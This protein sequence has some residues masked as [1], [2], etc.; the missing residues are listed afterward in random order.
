MRIRDSKHQVAV[1]SAACLAIGVLVGCSPDASNDGPT[2]FKTLDGG[3]GGDV[4]NIDGGATDTPGQADS[5]SKDSGP[6]PVDAGGPVDVPLP[7][8]VAGPKTCTNDGQCTDVPVGPCESPVCAFG[9]CVGTAAPDGSICDDG[10]KCSTGHVCAAGQCQSGKAVNCDDD[11]ECTADSCLADTGCIHEA[12]TAPCGDGDP[13]SGQ[14]QCKGG[15]CEGGNTIS[16][17]D[18]NACTTDACNPETGTCSYQPNTKPCSDGNACTANDTCTLGKCKG[19]PMATCASD[20][21]CNK[22]FC[23]PETGKCEQKPAP[24]KCDDGDACTTGDTC[25]GGNCDAE[26]LDCDDGNT[27]TDDSCLG[28]TGCVHKANA[29]GC[30]DTGACK[31]GVCK[32]GKCQVGDKTGC[33]DNNPCTKDACVDKKGCVFTPL[34]DGTGCGDGDACKGKSACKAGKCNKGIATDCD[35]N[36]ACTDDKCDPKVGCSWVANTAA[37]NDGNACTKTDACKGGKCAGSGAVKCNDGNACTSDGCNA[38]TGCVHKSIEGQKCDDGSSC[39]TG[40][41]CKGGKCAAAESKCDDGKV[42]TIDNC[43][44]KGN[45]S[46]TGKTGACDDGNACTKND[47]CKAGKCIGQAGASCNDGNPCTTDSCDKVAGKCVHKPVVGDKPVP[48]DDG[49]VCTSGETCKAGKCAPATAA[50][51][52]DGNDCTADT[53]DP[54][55]GKCSF[56]PKDGPCDAGDVCTWGDTC[57]NGKCIAG[58]NQTCNDG[59]PCTK[60]SCDAKTGKCSYAPT[61]DGAKCDD[62]LA[63]STGDTCK[64][65]KCT[66]KTSNCMLYKVDFTCGKAHGWQFHNQSNNT[67]KWAVDKTPA[68]AALAKYGCTMNLNDGKDYCHATQ[69]NYC[70]VPSAWVESPLIDATKHT[71]KLRLHFHTYYDLDGP[72]GSGNPNYDRPRI[73]VRGSQNQLLQTILLSKEAKGCAGVPCQKKLLVLQRDIDVAS[74][75]K[76]RLRLR[77]HEP[78]NYD[79]KGAGWFVDRINVIPGPPVEVCDNNKDDDGDGLADCKDPDCKGKVSCAEICVDGKDNDFDDKV[80]CDDPDC[81]SNVVCMDALFSTAFHCEESAFAYE[82]AGKNKVSWAVDATPS[83]VKPHSGKCTLN[84]NNGTNYCG[85]AGCSGQN[86]ATGG[87]ATTKKAIDT[88][89]YKKLKV[90]FWSSPWVETSNTYDRA[91]LQVSNDNFKG[92]VGGAASNCNGQAASCQT[93]GTVSMQLPKQGGALKN[94]ASLALDVSKFAGSPV[95]IRFRFAS[96]DGIQNNNPGWFIDDLAL[97]GEK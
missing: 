85:A 83:S 12:N 6:D 40:E 5:G 74:G 64:A 44:A 81:A 72:P 9:I 14:G 13:C 70:Q 55:T 39:T 60:D 62:G 80:D 73:E 87:T 92:C 32:G 69:G 17:D 46:W 51:C 23:N 47:T 8:D 28:K 66:P 21:P 61:A 54:K 10:N 49:D 45:C 96:C 88:K 11:N 58:K 19:G 22:A 79:N 33:E 48:C 67:V 31:A 82:G 41:V 90:N 25:K 7:E 36:N 3:N 37:C 89:G 75:Q 1:W 76:F 2:T 52:D 29:A 84:F 43:D 26:P 42:C 50:K 53:C 94:W 78:T 4:A 20:Q 91:W 68:V 59:S 86:N 27:C 56:G 57:K 15:K 38:K 95:K 24:G 35:D 34:K 63:C 30:S 97:V 93:A 77:L 18:N 16:C 71:G 65:G